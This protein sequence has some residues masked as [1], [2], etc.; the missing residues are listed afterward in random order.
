MIT[1]IPEEREILDEGDHSMWPD[2]LEQ[3]LRRSQHKRVVLIPPTADW[4]DPVQHRAHHLAHAFARSGYLTFFMTPNER[5]DRYE[6]GFHPINKLLYVANVPM[7][8]FRQVSKPILLFNH[9]TVVND[10]MELNQPDV[11]YDY[12][13]YIGE[14]SA[15][16]EVDVYTEHAHRFLLYGASLV[17]AADDRLLGKARQERPDAVY[18]PDGIDYSYFGSIY[19]RQGL[20]PEAVS[21]IVFSGKPI[22]GYYG[23]FASWIDYPLLM[24]SAAMRPQY[25]FVLIGPDLDGSLQASGVTSEANIAYLGAKPYEDVASY[26]PFFEVGIIPFKVNEYTVSAFPLKMYEYMA[27]GR[28]VVATELPKC[29][30]HPYVHTAMN[31]KQFV[32]QLDEALRLGGDSRFCAR[33]RENAKAQSW[34]GRAAFVLDMLKRSSR[35]PLVR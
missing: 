24:R 3:L 1:A 12:R 10:V 35:M 30:Q 32:V 6:E 4:R 23:T 19:Y 33:L 20:V 11:I 7:R 26:L 15:G 14:L 17:I 9:P 13:D 5:F 25:Q 22:I 29:A 18:C 8:T 16:S 34:D 31:A 27:A 2:R 21:D 28:P